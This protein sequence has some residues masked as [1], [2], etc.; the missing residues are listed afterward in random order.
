[1]K[2]ATIVLLSLSLI[3]VSCSF[4]VRLDPSPIPYTEEKID[5]DVGLFV[6]QF[7]MGQIHSRSGLCLIG[8]VH[9]WNVETG[10]ALRVGAERVFKRVFTKVEILEE[11]GEFKDKPLTLL[12]T[13]TIQRFN[14]SQ[15]LAAE[16]HLHC[17]LVDQVGE[18]VYENTIPSK[19]GSHAGTGCLLGVWGGQKALSETSNEAFNMAFAH[20]ANDIVKNVDFSPYL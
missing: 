5:L 9:T 3:L 13:P 8:M 7:Q 18:V 4:A 11:V 16:L 15:D 17:R 10:M 14:I 19:G 20:L 12:I 2:N 1:M 6:D